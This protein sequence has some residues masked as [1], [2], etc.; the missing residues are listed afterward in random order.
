MKVRFT[1]WLAFGLLALAIVIGVVGALVSMVPVVVAAAVL[2]LIGLAYLGPLPY[3]VVRDT[4]LSVPVMRGAGGTVVLKSRDRLDLSGAQVVVV[5][6]T[7]RREP[8][9]AYRRF[10]HPGDWAALAERTAPTRDD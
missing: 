5:R 8:F 1:P 2:G 7:G 3:L 10:A 4:G 9:G 6:S